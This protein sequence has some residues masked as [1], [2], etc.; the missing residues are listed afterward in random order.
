[1]LRILAV[2]GLALSARQAFGQSAPRPQF[3]VASIKQSKS[4]DGAAF[5]SPYPGGRFLARNASIQQLMRLAY[6]LLDFQIFGAP[7]WLNTE[8]YD[9]EAKA[10]KDHPFDVIYSMLQSLLE[11]R[12]QLKFHRETKE[13][14]VYALVVAKSGKLQDTGE[15]D[16]RPATPRPGRWKCGNVATPPGHITGDGITIALLIHVLSEST[17]RIVLDKTNLTGKYDVDLQFAPDQAQFQA[18]PSLPPTPLACLN[19]P[20]LFTALQEQ[21]GL[22]LESQKGPVEIMVIDHVERPSDN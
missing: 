13:E 6:R 1:M 17:G 12:L 5:F 7:A 11:E 9:I 10:A 15:C 2:A 8:R 22:K 18:P 14:T 21:L 19:G 3:E 16:A 4:G 20:S